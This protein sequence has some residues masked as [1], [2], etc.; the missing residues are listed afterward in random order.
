[1]EQLS[2][3]VTCKKDTERR[4]VDISRIFLRHL[5]A[6]LSG[7]TTDA[8]SIMA[9]QWDQVWRCAIFAVLDTH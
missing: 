9:T 4:G 8:S 2:G 5:N 7:L 6:L 3:T 1:M